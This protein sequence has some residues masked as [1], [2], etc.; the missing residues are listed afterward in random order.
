MPKGKIIN[1]SSMASTGIFPYISPYCASKRAMDILFNSLSIEL[2]NDDI[3]I[4]SIKPGVIK[5][6]IWNKSIT[7]NKARLEKL[8]DDF[9]EKYGKELLALS[10]NANKNNY[11][12]LEP[13]KVAQ[14]ILKALKA[15][16]PKSSYC[17]G[18]D[19]IIVC[20]LAKLPQDFLNKIIRLRLKSQT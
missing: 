14:I 10:E 15:K 4:I 20:Q 18:W 16:K 17:V 13:Q 11:K 3:K 5:T 8:P 2:K 1:I 12:A 7:R 19:S 6:P 9:K